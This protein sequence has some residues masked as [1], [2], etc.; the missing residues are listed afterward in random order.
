MRVKEAGVDVFFVFFTV[1]EEYSTLFI[2]PGAQ[3]GTTSASFIL[4]KHLMRAAE[5]LQVHIN[6]R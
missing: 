3:R 1:S 2:S 5:N 6:Y 4:T